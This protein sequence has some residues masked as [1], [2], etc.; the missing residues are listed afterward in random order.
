MAHE[1]NNPLAIMV[2]E[3]GWMQDLMQSDAEIL[4]Q[5]GHHEEY[6]RALQQIQTHGRRCK[7]ITVKL[8][9]SARNNLL[10]LAAHPNKRSSPRRGRPG[11][12]TGPLR[13]HHPSPELSPRLPTIQ[14]SPLEL[15][16]IMI[17]LTP[18]RTRA[19][20]ST[21]VP[22]GRKRGGVLNEHQRATG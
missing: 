15:Q 3:A 14:A 12:V 18:W 8:L 21:S 10:S 2:E 4:A 7:E 17:N 22:A 19:A 11:R 5:T 6:Q 9:G 1:I 13:K 20:R 16:Q